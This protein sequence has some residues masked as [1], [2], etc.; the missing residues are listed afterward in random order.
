MAILTKNKLIILFVMMLFMAGFL[1]SPK[2]EAETPTPTPTPTPAPDGLYSAEVMRGSDPTDPLMTTSIYMQIRIDGDNVVLGA[3][4]YSGSIP[5]HTVSN[6]SCLRSTIVEPND[7]THEMYIDYLGLFD[8]DVVYDNF[9]NLTI[10]DTTGN[11]VTYT[12]PSAITE[13]AHGAFKNWTSLTS[14]V[15]PSSVEVIGSNAFS[16]SSVTSVDLSQATNLTD[17][18]TGTFQGCTS[19][20][21]IDLSN[22][23]ITTLYGQNFDGCTTLSSVKLPNTITTIGNMAFKDTSNLLRLSIPLNV[24]AMDANAFE[25]SLLAP[26]TKMLTFTGDFNSSFNDMATDGDTYV[27]LLYPAGNRTWE[28]D[29]LVKGLVANGKAA[30]YI[31]ATSK[32]QDPPIKVIY[33]AERTSTANGVYTFSSSGSYDALADIWINGSTI[34]P[35][36][37]TTELKA[38]GGV[39]ITFS[40]SYARTLTASEEYQLH[41]V[42]YDGYGIVNFTKDEV[43]VTVYTQASSSVSV[44]TFEPT[45]EETEEQ[46]P[47]S[48]EIE[49]ESQTVSTT[50]STE[51]IDTGQKQGDSMLI[52]IAVL[53]IVGIGGCVLILVK[54]QK[55]K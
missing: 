51:S 6:V 12:F 47:V 42:F 55:N 40:D 19:L 14:V 4:E 38:D 50:S 53:V 9:K 11:V 20:Q 25:D 31:V 46:Q 2:V 52:L 10:Y 30:S 29:I 27:K 21:S 48:S 5:P 26:K 37:Y 33:S 39:S 17:I 15:I 1:F 35:S 41:F 34:A 8:I 16:E 49:N 32:P 18:N 28:N 44:D 22:T 3:G 7:E 24:S 45:S 54:T 36:N 43:V 23:K 13:I